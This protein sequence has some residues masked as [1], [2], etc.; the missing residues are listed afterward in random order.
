VETVILHASELESINSRSVIY[1]RQIMRYFGQHAIRRFKGD[2]K[3]FKGVFNEL[4]YN[5]EE[6]KNGQHYILLQDIYAEKDDINRSHN[7]LQQYT[8]ELLNG[9]HLC[10][11]KKHNK[12]IK[13]LEDLN[14]LIRQ[15]MKYPEKFAMDSENIV[16]IQI[17]AN[18]LLEV[19]K[20][21]NVTNED[22]TNLITY[23]TDQITSLS[24]QN[25]TIHTTLGI[26][27]KNIKKRLRYVKDKKKYLKN[28]IIPKLTA[29]IVIENEKI[30]F[31]LYTNSSIESI[32]NKYSIP[33]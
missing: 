5:E 33:K 30:S 4:E 32:P 29:K 15:V 2:R 1:A 25:R 27:I 31:E 21:H 6:F 14:R 9:I 10:L 16:G 28:Y 22:L 17:S 23:Y 24:N 7:L 18:K 11:Y 3:Y 19:I 12:I 8:E 13:P 26:L 20:E